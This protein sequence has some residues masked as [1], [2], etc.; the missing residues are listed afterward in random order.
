MCWIAEANAV[1]DSIFLRQSHRPHEHFKS[2]NHGK[3]GNA[4]R[5]GGGP[6]STL[7]GLSRQPGDFSRSPKVKIV[8]IFDK[9]FGR[10]SKG[11]PDPQDGPNAFKQLAPLFEEIGAEAIGCCPENW[12]NAVLTITCD[13]RRIDYSLKN[14]R[15][16]QGAAEISAILAQLAEKLYSLM[17]SNGD[18]WTKAELRYDQDGDSWKFKSNFTY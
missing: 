18:R 9:L 8:G 16:E 3:Q 2:R 15:G 7:P 10:T 5:V 14:H 6:K 17:A 13:G 4:R 12:T 11:A 1:L